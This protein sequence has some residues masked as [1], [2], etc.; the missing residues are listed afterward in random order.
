[1]SLELHVY[2]TGVSVLLEP[3]KPVGCAHCG[4]DIEVDSK[5]ALSRTFAHVINGRLSLVICDSCQTA[6]MKD[7][8]FTPIGNMWLDGAFAIAQSVFA[9]QVLAMM[10]NAEESWE[11]SLH[12]QE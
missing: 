8:V 5:K 4:L 3:D 2:L 9:A 7:G 6:L 10:E 12:D 11:A 1:M